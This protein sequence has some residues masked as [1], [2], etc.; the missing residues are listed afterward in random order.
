MYIYYL[1]C[2]YVAAFTQASVIN[3]LVYGYA[4][5]FYQH[6]NLLLSSLKQNVGNVEN[7]VIT[8]KQLK[9]RETFLNSCQVEKI[10]FGLSNF[11]EKSTLPIFQLCILCRT[12]Y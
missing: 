10:N 4:G 9:Y 6:S 2:C 11:I 3:L 1:L 12:Y 8:R 5:D 7:R